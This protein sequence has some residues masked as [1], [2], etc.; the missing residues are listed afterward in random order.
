MDS[1]AAASEAEAA[2]CGLC[3]CYAA[4]AAALAERMDPAGATTVSAAASAACGPCFC[5]AAAA[6]ASAAAAGRNA[7]NI[8]TES[9]E[10]R[11]SASASFLHPIKPYLAGDPVSG[12]AI[13]R[14][15]R[16]NRQAAAFL[17][18]A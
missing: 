11:M 2:A 16:R 13:L 9:S 5:Y 8:A 18:M 6:T 15:C 7:D 17:A 14:L 4:A 12:A 3:Y 10:L 1:L